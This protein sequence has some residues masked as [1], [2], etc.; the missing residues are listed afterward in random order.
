MY[1]R[2]VS[3]RIFVKSINL[4]DLVE[5]QDVYSQEAML[6][7]PE[8]QTENQLFYV[9]DPSYDFHVCW[10]DIRTYLDNVKEQ[11]E[12]MATQHK[13]GL[14]EVKKLKDRER[15]MGGS[16]Y[17]YFHSSLD[18]KESLISNS[19]NKKIL[20][21]FHQKINM[22]F[23][24][25]CSRNSTLLKGDLKD[26]GY[27]PYLYKEG[28]DPFDAAL[29]IGDSACL[30]A[31]AEYL[32]LDEKSHDKDGL[33]FSELNKVSNN[34]LRALMEINTFTKVMNTRHKKLQDAFIEGL[35]EENLYSWL[36]TSYAQYEYKSL[37]KVWQYPLGEGQEVL[38]LLSPSVLM[39]MA[40]HTRIHRTVTEAVRNK[41]LTQPVEFKSMRVRINPRI[42]HK[43][44]L[45]FIQAIMMISEDHLTGDLKHVIY[46]IWEV[47]KLTVVL[48]FI[49]LEWLTMLF[50][51]LQIVWHNDSLIL[52][53]LVILFSI[54]QLLTDLLGAV[55]DPGHYFSQTYNYMDL[56]QYVSMPILSGLVHFTDIVDRSET[57]MNLY[58]NFIILIAGFRGITG[59]KIIGS[60]RY[61]IAMIIQVFIDMTGLAV[62]TFLSIVIFSVIGINHLSIENQDYEGWLQFRAQLNYYYNTMFGNW[63][64]EADDFDTNRFLVYISSGVFF[65]FIMANLVI[66]MI[67]QTFDDFQG[68]KELVDLQQI[69]EILLEYGFVLSYFRPNR[70]TYSDRE[71]MGFISLIKKASEDEKQDELHNKVD[72]IEKKLETIENGIE[73]MKDKF[74]SL[75]EA[76][77]TLVESSLKTMIESSIKPLSDKIDRLAE[78]D[79]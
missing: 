41:K 13:E 76:N 51:F 50:F 29:D 17:E 2:E 66:G 62:I 78:K 35:F 61:L 1:F 44:C 79:E 53:L 54:F 8:H 20:K 23:L 39:S 21:I 68:T 47:N 69:L 73:G 27:H 55:R 71:G 19:M 30:D 63:T 75:K 5:A 6:S 31:F 74:E 42:F 33:E 26:Y 52:T 59:L 58:I 72:N 43:S 24:E 36:D 60:M 18:S 34:H 57:R 9:N 65:A 16:L 7:I 4:D 12:E 25:V 15:V 56:L 77:K 38:S 14:E 70:I 49:M 22:L 45:D 32:S 40:D 3:D 46:H 11:L 37:E 10:K 67:S 28:F 48:P 64:E